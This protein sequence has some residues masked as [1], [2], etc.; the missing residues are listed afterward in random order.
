MVN[1]I[2]LSLI[3]TASVVWLGYVGLD[4]LNNKHNFT[5]NMLFGSEDGT[6]LIINRFNEISIDQVDQF[7][8]APLKELISNLPTDNISALFAS[9]KLPHLYIQGQKNWDKETIKVL[10]QS[11]SNDLKIETN[12][13]SVGGYHGRYFKSKLYLKKGDIPA[14]TDITEFNY[15]KKASASMISFRENSTVQS[16]TDI[17]H[18]ENGKVEFITRNAEIEQGNQVKDE[19]IFSRVISSKI[20]SYHFFE[21]DYYATVDEVFKNGPMNS[22]CLNGFVSIVYGGEPAIVADYIVGQDP[23]L[24]L[25]DLNQTTNET[26]FRTPLT[27]DFPKKGKYF[28][29]YLDDLVVISENENTCDNLIA[30]FKLGTTIALNST[31]QHSFFGDLP[32]SVS[33]RFIS[34]DKRYSK[35][36]YQGRIL[37]TTFGESE[38]L[39]LNK[40]SE[41]LA[42]NCG[43]DVKDFLVLENGVSVVA[44][45][46]NG[47]VSYF[48]KGK[49]MWKK[50][51]NTDEVYKVQSIDLHESGEDYLLLN[52]SSHI[53]LWN[54]KGEEV[55]GFP[56]ELEHDATNE[57]KFYR[58]SGKSYFLIGNDNQQVVH[59]DAKGRELNVLK[60]AINVTRQIDVWVSL[61][62]L[63]AGFSDGKMFYMYHLERSKQHRDFR[64]PSNSVAVKI[65]NELVQFG[66]EDN[67]LVRVDQKGTAVKLFSVNNGKILQYDQNG[68][69]P[70]IVVQSANE[71]DLV[72]QQGISFGKITLPF[73]EIEHVFIENS[74]SG[75]NL[76]SI[77]DGIENNV[78]LYRTN[79]EKVNNLT[80]EGQQKAVITSTKTSKTITTVVD[81]FIVQYY[82]N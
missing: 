11:V 56:I 10:F 81:Q 64:T 63:F 9:Q 23:V 58:W 36:I 68:K 74:V 5:P 19:V 2:I 17:Y 21:R 18:Q 59:Y 65:P 42:M 43:F 13:F 15:D 20:N 28:V 34:K 25:N 69:N 29:K 7:E 75:N 32:K 77:I 6:V 79:G 16:V 40:K 4:I 53:H 54:K 48:D 50:T 78:Y 71:L 44:L 35:A 3:V 14:Y 60:T 46:K 55:S 31:I 72:N 73:N 57:V 1:K 41:T 12:S 45:G 61:Q 22:W 49:L 26:T 51:L 33:E 8:E 82:I 76:V 39:T 67:A 66:I 80:F 70:Y 27:S 38:N 30:D 52:T 37:E 47:E 62:Q 24:I